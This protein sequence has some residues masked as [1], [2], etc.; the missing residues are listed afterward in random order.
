MPTATEY[1]WFET[2]RAREFLN[3]T[4]SVREIVRRSG[5]T[6]GLALVSAMHITAAVHVNDD[7]RGLLS[8]I[9]EWADRLAPPSHYAPHR[10]GESNGDA[11]L[12][13]LLLGHQIIPPSR[14]ATSTSARGSR[15]STG[16]STVG[17]VSA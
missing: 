12:K 6:E 5:V 16:S 7:E 4:E 1:L 15:S 14:R 11:H 10:T 2:Q 13:N 17:D 8:D 3:I 9:E